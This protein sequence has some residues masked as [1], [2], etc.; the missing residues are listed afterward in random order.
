MISSRR[1]LTAFVV[2]AADTLAGAIDLD[3]NTG[4]RNV[5]ISFNHNDVPDRPHRPRHPNRPDGPDRFERYD[6]D[7]IPD[8]EDT[9]E[10]GSLFCYLY[11]RTGFL[12]T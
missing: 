5:T 6:R 4:D 1:T 2:V 11:D 10:F 3:T 7:D 12:G 8:P 9:L